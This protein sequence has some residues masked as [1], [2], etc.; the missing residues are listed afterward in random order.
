MEFGAELPL[1][2]ASFPYTRMASTFAKNST[3]SYLYHQITD[4]TFAE[5]L[6]DGTSGFWISNNITIDTA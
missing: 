1:P 3:S 5:E 6:W 4:T 2:E